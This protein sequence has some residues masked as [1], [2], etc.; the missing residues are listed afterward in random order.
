M[1]ADLREIKDVVFYVA[2]S[3]GDTTKFVFKTK[4]RWIKPI[5]EYDDNGDPINVVL[6]GAI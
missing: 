1:S 6:K 3:K 4:E 5:W 2:N